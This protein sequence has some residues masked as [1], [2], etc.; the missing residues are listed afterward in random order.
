MIVQIKYVNEE[1]EDTFYAVEMD[2][3]ALGEFI[4]TADRLQEETYDRG[5]L[6]DQS[7][8]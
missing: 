1:G 7:N 4:V 2:Y 6:D 8:L 5:P 3:K